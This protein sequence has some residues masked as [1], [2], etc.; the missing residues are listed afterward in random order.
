MPN[1]GWEAGVHQ[2]RTFVWWQQKGTVLRR[3]REKEYEKKTVTVQ[4]YR[5][6]K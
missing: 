6:S 4:K 2:R 5:K 3:E 1:R